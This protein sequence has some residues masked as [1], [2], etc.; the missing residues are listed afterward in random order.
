VTPWPGSERFRWPNFRYARTAEEA[1]LL[2]IESIDGT[3]CYVLSFYDPTSETHYQMW[4]GLPDFLVRR[5]EMMAI[6]HYM[7]GSFARF[8][9]PTIVI[10]PPPLSD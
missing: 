6:G 4:I 7:V 3:P 2:G 8:D 9:D 1:R 5:Y 10:D